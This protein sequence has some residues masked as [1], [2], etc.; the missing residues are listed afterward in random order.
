MAV[1]P[2]MGAEGVGADAHHP[3]PYFAGDHEFRT[4][5]DMR[6]AM[7]TFAL[8][9]SLVCSSCVERGEADTSDSTPMCADPPFEPL[10][11]VTWGF[12]GCFDRGTTKSVDGMKWEEHCVADG[13]HICIHS[14]YFNDND[15]LDSHGSFCAPT[16]ETDAQCPTPEGY[17]TSCELSSFCQINCD[18]DDVCPAGLTCVMGACIAD[19]GGG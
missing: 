5:C 17:I 13:R 14:M 11:L 7:L 16:C 10:G 2:D 3:P 8:L 15:V 18:D 9:S 4:W 19:P 12:C 6:T 1:C